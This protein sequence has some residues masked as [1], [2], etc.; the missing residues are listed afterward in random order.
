MRSD[1][2]S[3]ET[4][5]RDL[6]IAEHAHAN[7]ELTKENEQLKAQNKKLEQ[8]IKRLEALLAIKVDANRVDGTCVR[9][10]DGT[11]VRRRG[12]FR[13]DGFRRTDLVI[14]TRRP[15]NGS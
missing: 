6:K 14:V 10:V 9:R 12:T 11:C 8:R 2:T 15:E 5:P 7:A 13:I 1:A 3:T 4:D